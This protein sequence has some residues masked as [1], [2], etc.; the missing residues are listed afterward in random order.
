[1]ERQQGVRGLVVDGSLWEAGKH[2]VAG[3]PISM[4]VPCMNRCHNLQHSDTMTGGTVASHTSVGLQGDS[5]LLK[6]RDF[7]LTVLW[8]LKS[9]WH[10]G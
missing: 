7:M 5:A 6:D 10:R 9:A 1:M 8:A 3:E 4:P 2:Q